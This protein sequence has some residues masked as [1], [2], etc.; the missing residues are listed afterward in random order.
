MRK[1]IKVIL[2]I[3]GVVIGILL[4]DTIQALVFNNSPNLKIRED[5]NGGT[6]YYIDKGV[7]ANTYQCTDGERHTVFKWEKYTCPVD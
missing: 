6:L 7:I 5:Y 2:I 3:V 1:G 4:L